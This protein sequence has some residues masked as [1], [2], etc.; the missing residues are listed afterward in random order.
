MELVEE[1]IT[2]AD[3]AGVEAAKSIMRCLARLL[4][5]VV[6]E[7]A[8]IRRALE[9]CWSSC[10]DHRRSDYFWSLMDLLVRMAFQPVLMEEPE[11]R[12][13]LFG[14]YLAELKRQGENIASLFNLAAEQIVN[15]WTTT[16]SSPSVD[17]YSVRFVVDA[18]TFGLIKRRD[19]M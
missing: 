1:S 3:V 15:A 17:Q 9:Q 19:E 5:S 16:G 13:A 8:M 2:A 7:P 11:L 10:Y 18:V 6:N 4:P 12:P 14:N